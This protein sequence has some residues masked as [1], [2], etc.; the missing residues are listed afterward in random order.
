MIDLKN[1]W[2]SLSNNDS[3]TSVY[4]IDSLLSIFPEFKP[5]TDI[6]LQFHIFEPNII[7]PYSSMLCF[8]TEEQEPN[9]SFIVLFD[10]TDMTTSSEWSCI[11]V[12][13]I[14]FAPVPTICRFLF[15]LLFAPT[16]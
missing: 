2:L 12:C 9:T 10:L 16:V 15:I 8:S 14:G 1:N 3:I 5:H 4:I 6:S 7:Y 13:D 11:C